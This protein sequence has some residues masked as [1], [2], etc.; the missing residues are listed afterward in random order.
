MRIQGTE[1]EE[2]MGKIK[3]QI[4]L[5][6]FSAFFKLAGVNPGLLNVE[7][8]NERVMP[9]RVVKQRKVS[10][11]FGITQDGYTYQDGYLKAS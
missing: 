6:T 8:L 9:L 7:W 5:N 2:K 4:S 10:W 3:D 11:S 1:E